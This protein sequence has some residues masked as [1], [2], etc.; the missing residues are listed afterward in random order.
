[1]IIEAIVMEDFVEIVKWALSRGLVW[2]SGSK[3]IQAGLWNDYKSETYVSI[4]DN[5]AYGRR[6]FVEHKI[7]DIVQFRIHA[8]GNQREIFGKKFNLK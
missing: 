5:I 1:M 7:I 4:V 2:R 6:V 8:I 3:S